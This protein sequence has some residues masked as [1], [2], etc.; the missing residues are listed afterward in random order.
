MFNHPPLPGMHDNGVKLANTQDAPT[1]FAKLTYTGGRFE[2]QKSA[3]ICAATCLLCGISSPR[4]K[5]IDY[6][7]CC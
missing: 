7:T 1:H 3:F 5:P 6:K 4:G 2:G